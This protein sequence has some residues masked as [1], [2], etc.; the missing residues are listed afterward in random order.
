MGTTS[1]KKKKRRAKTSKLE[2]ISRSAKSKQPVNSQIATLL[3][4]RIV[5]GVYSNDQ[6]LPPELELVQEF[7]V[8]RHTV[9]AALQ[10]LVVDG[11]IERRRGSGTTVVH[12]DF[13][14]GTW[15]V[16]ALDFLV[17]NF[18]ET[19]L[20]FSGT[21]PATQNPQVA[22]LFHIPFEGKLFKVVRLLKSQT[23]PYAYSTIFSRPEYGENVP[24]RLI[25]KRIFVSLID[26]YCG[27]QAARVRQTMAATNCPAI[28]AKELKVQPNHPMLR[29]E[30]RYMTRSGDL[31]T[32]TELYC[33]SE[34]YQPVAVFSRQLDVKSAKK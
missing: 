13:M 21:V 8:S 31:I 7:K 1:V 26:E 5:D 34:N 24:Q 16:N 28:A 30:R 19:K 29:L 25:S 3:R 11:L 23:G 4:K 22:K 33:L 9:R 6:G 12:R 10:R 17:Q 2:K 20:L 32:H 27:V 14:A 15:V 18:Y